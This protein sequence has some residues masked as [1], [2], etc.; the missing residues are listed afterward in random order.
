MR[1]AM[2][3]R[4]G[5]NQT[6]HVVTVYRERKWEYGGAMPAPGTL[7]GNDLHRRQGT[8]PEWTE[9]WPDLSYPFT[10][11][12]RAEEGTYGSRPA[13]THPAEY[14]LVELFRDGEAGGVRQQR[15]GRAM[16]ELPKALAS[17]KIIVAKPSM[18]RVS[19]RWGDDGKTGEFD[20]PPTRPRCF[21]HP[22]DNLGARQ[23]LQNLPGSKLSAR[24]CR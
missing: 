3:P 8:K 9:R 19:R 11:A 5:S 7:S 24:P 16:R 10:A 23:P 4:Q 21:L 17:T 1:T 12:T 15:P 14:V 20:Q 13:T 6:T 22:A 18:R 2:S